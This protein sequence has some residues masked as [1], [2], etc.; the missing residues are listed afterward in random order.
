MDFQSAEPQELPPLLWRTGHFVDRH[1]DAADRRKLV[2]VPADSLS[3]SFGRGGFYRPGADL[4][5]AP[6]AGVLVDRWNRRRILFITQTLAMAQAFLLALLVLKTVSPY[7][8][9]S[10]LSIFLGCVNALDIPTRQAFVVD[11]VEKHEDLGNAV[12]LNSVIVNGARLVG[13]SVAGI[14]IAAVGEQVC[15]LSQ[16]SEFPRSRSRPSCHARH[17]PQDREST[18]SH[19]AGF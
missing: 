10:S 2:G 8:T 18:Q 1:L 16:R 15:F 6:L 7:G 5:F 13:P 12:A 4:L 14:L 19:V 17:A 3:C 11:M 9:S